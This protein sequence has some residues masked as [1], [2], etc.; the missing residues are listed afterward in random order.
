MHSPSRVVRIQHVQSVDDLAQVLRKLCLI[1]V[2][3][4]LPAREDEEL[5]AAI[6]QETKLHG[7]LRVDEA[8]ED[9]GCLLL[10]AAAIGHDLDRG[11]DQGFQVHDTSP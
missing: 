4:V 2:L 6:G 5:V 8:Q 1:R 3:D 10:D 9:L 11:R 7:D